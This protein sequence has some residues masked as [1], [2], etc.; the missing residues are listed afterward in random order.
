MKLYRRTPL[1]SEKIGK[2]LAHILHWATRSGG[3]EK[4]IKEINGIVFELDLD[5]VIDAS[6]YYSDTFEENIESLIASSL[7]PGMV[8]MDIGANIGYHTFRM[9][10][11]VAPTGKVY[12]IE[13]TQRAF[14]RLLHNADLNPEI[15][16]IRYLKYALSNSDLGTMPVTF[17]SSYRLDDSR[18]ADTE[19]IEFLTLDSLSEREQIPHVDFIKIDVD[20]FESKIICG[21]QRLLSR[22]PAPTLL[23]EINPSEMA[24]N[25]DNPEELSDVFINLG[26]KFQTEYG[27]SIP[28]LK[29]FC[30]QKWNSS[31]M[32]LGKV[33]N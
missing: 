3:T 21:A 1:H 5:Q 12:A 10:K 15:K 14:N 28:D 32:V 18:D 4:K 27:E 31:T 25:G 7:K 9:A 26:Y 24:R 29:E 2:F 8:V 13:P 11:Q 30:R 16:N 17:E 19:L 20:G 23:L 6:L 33:S 22:I